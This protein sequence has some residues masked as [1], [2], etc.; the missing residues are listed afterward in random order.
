M[1]TTT[2]N[3]YANDPSVATK[4][5]KLIVDTDKINNLVESYLRNVPDST[6]EAYLKLE[7]RN[8][9]F[10]HILAM[11]KVLRYKKDDL[12]YL[13]NNYV[14]IDKYDNDY[15]LDKNSYLIDYNLQYALNNGYLPKNDITM[16]KDL[17]GV[18]IVVLKQ[19][20]KK[21]NNLLIYKYLYYP[22]LFLY[23]LNSFFYNIYEKFNTNYGNNLFIMS[24]NFFQNSNLNSINNAFSK[25]RAENL[26]SQT[27]I[28]ELY[29]SLVSYISRPVILDIDSMCKLTDYSINKDFYNIIVQILKPTTKDLIENKVILDKLKNNVG[30]DDNDKYNSLDRFVFVVDHLDSFL[31]KL[32]QHNYVVNGGPQA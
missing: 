6:L 32:K 7:D 20:N 10:H 13:I 29:K 1:K 31:S 15:C 23:C 18:Y 21:Q 28:I 3:L 12:E 27:N 17:K 30:K 16:K 26:N 5:D 9:M 11:S 4:D 8:S 25:V 2:P 22:Y 19:L 14:K 24:A